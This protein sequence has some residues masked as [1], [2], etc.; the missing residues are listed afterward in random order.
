MVVISV[1]LSGKEL[2][3][4]DRLVE[5]F[6]Y[7]SRSSAVR[8]ALYAFIAQHRLEFQGEVDLVMTLVYATDAHREDVHHITEEASDLIRTT[9]HNHLGERCVDVLVLRGDGARIHALVDQ[10]T[11]FKDVR[12]NATPV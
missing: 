6:K 2:H 7:D 1:S 9:V 11:R 5:H 8:D 3:E 4:F 10:L 12:V